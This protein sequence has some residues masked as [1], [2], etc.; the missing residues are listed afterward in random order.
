MHQKLKFCLAFAN[1]GNVNILMC[2]LPC[3]KCC[4]DNFRFA[5][6]ILWVFVVLED[7]NLGQMTA[8]LNG[9]AYRLLCRGVVLC[10]S[11]HGLVLGGGLNTT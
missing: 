2:R 9:D 7:F 1:A 3:W 11:S 5:I 8:C 6:E 4:H 10:H